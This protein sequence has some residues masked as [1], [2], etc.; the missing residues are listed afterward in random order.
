M[1]QLM[2]IA[3]KSDVSEAAVREALAKRGVT[4]SRVDIVTF[5]RA[6]A[7]SGNLHWL[8][9]ADPRD[10]WPTPFRQARAWLERGRLIGRATRLILGGPSRAV[11]RAIRSNTAALASARDADVIVSLDVGTHLAAWHLARRFGVAA[12]N[13]WPG[14]GSWANPPSHP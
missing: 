5:D 8:L 11:W 14:L 2:V 13:R 3:V 12:V 7:A 1:T 9:L 4:A 10:R 6:E